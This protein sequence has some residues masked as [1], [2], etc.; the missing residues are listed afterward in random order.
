MQS[1]NYTQDSE[2]RHSVVDDEVV[3]AMWGMVGWRGSRE[4]EP[5]GVAGGSNGPLRH[6]E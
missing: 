6:D 4:W 3:G 1:L 2:W 5:L